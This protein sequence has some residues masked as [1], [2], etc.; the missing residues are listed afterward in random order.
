M[1]AAQASP[2]PYVPHVHIEH[3]PPPESIPFNLRKTM[4]RTLN[5]SLATLA[6]VVG[7]SACGKKD[8]KAAVATP[9][10]TAATTTTTTTTTTTPPAATTPAAT[11][12]PAAAGDVDAVL[13]EYEVLMND[14]AAAVQKAKSGDATASQDVAALS[15]RMQTTV[16]NLTSMAAKMTPEQQ[17]KLQ[18]L[19]MKAAADMQ[20]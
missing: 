5:L 8:D 2:S 7:L 4:S 18:D 20:K 9:G 16:Q 17:K 12:A 10:D 19:S 11:T 1:I 15:T 13:K 3:S 14:Y 6:I